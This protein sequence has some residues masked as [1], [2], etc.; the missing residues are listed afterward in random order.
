MTRDNPHHAGLP[1][2]VNW[3]TSWKKMLKSMQKGRILLVNKSPKDQILTNTIWMI[4]GYRCLTFCYYLPPDAG[5]LKAEFI[6]PPWC[7]WFPLS[8]VRPRGGKGSW[9]QPPSILAK[10]YFWT[11]VF[12]CF[13][14]RLF[15][16][17]G[18][19]ESSRDAVPGEMPLS[20]WILFFVVFNWDCVARGRRHIHRS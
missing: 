7:L 14:L 16:L 10:I 20:C 5:L 17:L 8:G 6:F 2:P 19:R 18:N 9:P 1:D 4:C 3:K 12:C 15:R 11:K 13:L